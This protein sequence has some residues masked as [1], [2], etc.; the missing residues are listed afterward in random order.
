M[1]TEECI[2]TFLENQE[3]L[4]PQAVAESYEAAEAFLED[5]MA[6]VVDSIEEVREYLEESGADVEGMS[7]EELEDASEVFALPDGK[8]LIVEG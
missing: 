5:C 7:D 8:Y 2:N 1:F 3:Q 6:Q 4:F